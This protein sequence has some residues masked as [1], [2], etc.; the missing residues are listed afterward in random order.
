M[1]TTLSAQATT[2]S[3]RITSAFRNHLSPREVPY[4]ASKAATGCAGPRFSG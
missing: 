1:V 3:L 2:L 4:M